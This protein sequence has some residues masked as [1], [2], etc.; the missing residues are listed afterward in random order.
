MIFTEITLKSI[1]I[2][3]FFVLLV[4]RVDFSKILNLLIKIIILYF[5]QNNFFILS[6]YTHTHT[7]IYNRIGKTIQREFDQ[8]FRVTDFIKANSLFLLYNSLG[9]DFKR[10]RINCIIRIH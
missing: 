1:A 9:S 3:T 4:G 10:R 8:K 7:H 2:Y 6:T 5:S